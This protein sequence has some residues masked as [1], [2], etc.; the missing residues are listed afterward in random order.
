MDAENPGK[1]AELLACK[2]LQA[3]GLSLLERNFHSRHGE[4]DLIM[5]H[6]DCVIFIEVRYRRESR[7]GSGAESVDRRKQAKILACAAYYLQRHP[8]AACCPCRF[9]VVAVSGAA[10]QPDI[11]WIQDAFQA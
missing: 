3:Q 6:R 9:D 4:I 11:L 1:T 7:F 10:G 8:Q 2:H 5:N